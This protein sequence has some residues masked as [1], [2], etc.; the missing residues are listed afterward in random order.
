MYGIFDSLI[1]IFLR[2]QGVTCR[3]CFE[4]GCVQVSDVNRFHALINRLQMKKKTFK[5]M[6]HYS[7]LL[8]GHDV[9][10]MMHYTVGSA[11]KAKTR[12]ADS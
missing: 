9:Y 6:C 5:C 7:N 12:G 8:L 3:R 11:I 10:C 4:Q 2:L 1:S